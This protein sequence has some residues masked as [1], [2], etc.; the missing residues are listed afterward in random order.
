MVDPTLSPSIVEKAESAS[1]NS[2]LKWFIVKY[3]IKV[4]LIKFESPI[5]FPE[6][7]ST[8]SGVENQLVEMGNPEGIS[9]CTGFVKETID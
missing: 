9:M 6:R 5:R 4:K 1:P 7:D 2:G 8:I 3:L